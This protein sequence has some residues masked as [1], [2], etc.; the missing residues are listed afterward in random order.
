MEAVVIRPFEARDGAEL[1]ELVRRCLREV[2]G[3]DYPTEVIDWMCAH[4]T[5]DRFVKLAGVREVW[6]AEEGTRVVGT[7]SR[8]GN[9][10]YSMFVSPDR[11]GRGI[12][13]ALM[14]HIEALAAAQGYD[15]MET[16]AS[17]SG[18]G[19]YHRLGYRDVRESDTDVGLTYILRKRF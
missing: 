12:G 1:S 2:N 9:R 13:R 14:R 8:D 7:V 18:H 10:V 17:M 19:F 16:G 5:G 4:F 15:H 11:A 3:R 6:V